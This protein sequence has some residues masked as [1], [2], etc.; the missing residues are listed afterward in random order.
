M[1]VSLSGDLELFAAVA[2]T[3]TRCTLA[4]RN[5]VASNLRL[6]KCRRASECHRCWR[7]TQNQQIEAKATSHLITH[8]S[9]TKADESDSAL[10]V[11]AVVSLAVIVVP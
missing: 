10:L 2:V 5:T 6:L 4:E 9:S 7:S 8:R 3:V 1:I 11:I